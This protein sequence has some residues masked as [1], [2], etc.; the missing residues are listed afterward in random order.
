[1]NTSMTSQAA[2]LIRARDADDVFFHL[3]PPYFQAIMGHYG[4]YTVNDF[5]NPLK[6]LNALKEIYIKSYPSQ[7]LSYMYRTM[8]GIVQKLQVPSAL[9]LQKFSSQCKNRDADNKLSNQ[10]MVIAQL[11]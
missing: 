6:M 1:M 3:D 8:L 7:I 10:L 9:H 11:F 4:G 2:Y 5:E